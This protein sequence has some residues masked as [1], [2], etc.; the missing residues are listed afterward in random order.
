M[1]H[2]VD[3]VWTDVS[4]ESIASIFIVEK[5]ASEEPAL[6]G[7]TSFDTR[8]T[9]RYIPEDDILHSHRSKNLKS[10]IYYY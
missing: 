4:E 7:E 5:S 8:S 3:L 10:Y 6:A 2:R 1:W 9:R